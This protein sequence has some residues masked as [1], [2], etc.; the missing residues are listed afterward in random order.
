MSL[1]WAAVLLF[2][3]LEARADDL[4]K[5]LRTIKAAD[6]QKHQVVLAS[7][8]FEGREA[9]SEGGHKAALYISELLSKWGLEPGGQD[10]TWFQPFGGEVTYGDLAEANALRVYKDRTMRSCDLYKLNESLMPLRVGRA[11]T[12]TGEIV[13][14]GYGITAPEYEY[15]DYKGLKAKEAIVLV[16]DHE[17]QE[18]DASSRWNGEKPT[19]YCDWEHKISNAERNGAAALM[20]VLD[21]VNHEERGIPEHDGLRWPGD[22]KEAKCRIPVVYL[23]ADAAEGLAKLASKSLKQLQHEIDTT[24]KPR[25]FR[26]ARPAKLSVAYRGLPGKGQKNIVAI[27]RGTDRPDEYVVI[28]AHYDHVG[29]GRAGSNGKAGEIHNGADDNASGTCALLEIAEALAVARPRRSIVCIWFDAEEKGLVGSQEWCRKPTVPMEKVVG[30]INLDM[31]GR[32]EVRDIKVG[33]EGGTHP[34]YPKLAALMREAERVF[35]VRF[36]WDTII[37]QNLIQRSDHWNFMQA[38]V[39]ATFLSG[40]LHGDYHTERDDADKINYPKEELIG[41]IVLWLAHRMAAMEGALK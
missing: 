16:L 30:M 26:V 18:R 37:N 20:I 4:D 14:A 35:Q 19:K 41:R 8:A 24:G 13:F 39:P 3:A 38:G 6:L 27:W 32:N 21:P 1:R 5:A 15:D 9:G 23:T 31:I 36:D 12:A 25:A 7:D 17:P 40:G 2:I 34:K 11:G 33:V 28:G 22:V 10:D 29:F